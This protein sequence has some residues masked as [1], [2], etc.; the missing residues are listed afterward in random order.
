V[1]T[2]REL[3]LPEVGG[4]AVE[5]A[6]TDA[7]SIAAALGELLDDP[8]RRRQLGVAAELR[9][10]AFTWQHTTEILATALHDAARGAS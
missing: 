10:R 5:Y 7:A 6:G 9:A 4:D 2:T 1:L 8:A 3:S